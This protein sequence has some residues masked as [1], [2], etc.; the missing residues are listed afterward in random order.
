MQ[1]A[2]AAS[3][4]STSALPRF[5]LCIEALDDLLGIF[6]PTSSNGASSQNCKGKERAGGITTGQT[7]E[8]AGPPG[9]GKTT[10]ALGMVMEARLQVCDT[11]R[12]R[13]ERERARRQRRERSKSRDRGQSLSRGRHGAEEGESGSESGHEK[14]HREGLQGG[15]ALIIG[16]LH[17]PQVGRYRS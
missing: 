11:A 1:S 7:V 6:G 16:K 13:E 3:L 10:I 14:Q 15:E 2:T 5:S 12:R 4:L 9:I 8:L 17:D